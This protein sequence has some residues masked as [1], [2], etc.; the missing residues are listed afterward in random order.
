LRERQGKRGLVAGN[1]LRVSRKDFMYIKA[2][3]EE[4]KP[5]LKIEIEFI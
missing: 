2:F 4:E 5:P 1:F 3:W